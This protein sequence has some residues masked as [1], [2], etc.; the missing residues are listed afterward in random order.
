VSE[1]DAI[2]PAASP[3][4]DLITVFAPPSEN[5]TTRYVQDAL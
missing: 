2:D 3:Y 1:T 4:T 5:V